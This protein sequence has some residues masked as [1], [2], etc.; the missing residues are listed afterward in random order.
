MKQNVLTITAADQKNP[1]VKELLQKL[2]EREELIEKQ[3]EIIEDQVEIIKENTNEIQEKT[4]EIQKLK[5]ENLLLKNEIAELKK[6]PKRPKIKANKKPQNSK[7]PQTNLNPPEK[8]PGSAKK[9]KQLEIHETKVLRPENMPDGSTL[10]RTR[11]YDV[12]DLRIVVHNTRYL[13]EEWETPDGEILSAQ[14]PKNE[15]QN[16]FGNELC[17]FILD[18]HHQCQVTQP[19]L[20]EQLREFGIDISEG[21]LN[22]ILIENNALFHQEKDEILQSALKVSSYIQVDDTGARHDGK[23][24]YCTQ[25]GNEFFAWFQ[26]TESKSRI[27]FLEILNSVYPDAGYLLNERAFEYMIVNGLPKISLE[28]LKNSLSNKEEA[29]LLCNSNVIPISIHLNLKPSEQSIKNHFLIKESWLDCLKKQNIVNKTHIKIATEAVLLAGALK[30]GLNDDLVILS[31]D[32]GQFNIP[33]LIHALCWIHEERHIKKLIPTIESYRVIQEKTLEDFWNLYR[34]IKDYKKN[35]TLELKNTIQILFDELFKRK[36]GYVLLDLVLQRTFLKKNELLVVLERPDIPLHNNGSETDIREYVKRKKVSG[37]TRS[38]SGQQSRDTF[39]SVKKTCRKLGL[40]FYTYLKDRL[41]GTFKIAKLGSLIE[42]AA[43]NKAA[44]T[45]KT[46]AQQG[47][48][49]A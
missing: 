32:A 49:A 9:S 11:S 40:S 46:Q 19:L 31:D 41:S 24:G 17:A 3:I 21:Q 37:G 43:A 15:S 27:N 2:Y 25:I 1:L 10:K 45:L 4:E 8:R 22:N 28:K 44:L 30:G 48:V 16:H 14:R 47:A 38:L 12:E 35:P 34:T 23:N 29:L 42:Q 26:S 33:F 39:A 18:Q 36:T 13:L 6:S 5:E 20:Y 7:N